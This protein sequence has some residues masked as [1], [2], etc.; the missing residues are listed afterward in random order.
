MNDFSI[1]KVQKA[2]DELGIEIEFNSDN[3]TD[4]GDFSDIPKLLEEIHAINCKN[5]FKDIRELTV[6]NLYDPCV[7]SDCDGY[8]ER[9]INGGGICNNCGDTSP[10]Y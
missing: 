5:Y 4:F 9:N 10:C 8:Y 3:P 1:E 7:I 2:A 6:K